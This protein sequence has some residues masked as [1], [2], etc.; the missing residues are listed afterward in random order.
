MIEDTQNPSINTSHM[1]QE[2]KGC[3]IEDLPF[4]EGVAYIQARWD[5][6][7][8]CGLCELACSMF[9]YGLLSRELSRIR[10]Y[11]YLTPI[12]KAVQNI[13]VQCSEEERECQKACPQSPPVC[14]KLW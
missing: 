6:C 8:G 14:Q 9:H 13:C 5:L 12:P 4:P 10:I 7:I 2:K 11:R 3:G 1:N